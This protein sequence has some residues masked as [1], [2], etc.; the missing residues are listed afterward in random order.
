MGAELTIH[1]GAKDSVVH[2]V[3]LAAVLTWI[4]ARVTAGVF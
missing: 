4:V 2:N 3:A 1:T